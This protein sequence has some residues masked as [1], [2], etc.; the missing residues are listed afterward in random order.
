MFIIIIIN[1]LAC[2]IIYLF[3]F[4]QYKSNTFLSFIPNYNTQNSQNNTQNIQNINYSLNE[5]EKLKRDIIKLNNEN[6]LLK[7]ENQKLK[8]EN[9]NLKNDINIKNINLNQYLLKIKELN[10]TLA[11]KNKEINNLINKLQNNDQISEY[12][13]KD[14]MLIIQIKSVN[15]KVDMSFACKKTDIFARIEEKLYNEYPEFKDLNTYY[16]VGGRMVKRFRNM[17]ENNIKNNDKILL[18]IYE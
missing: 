3:I 12:I 5:I 15:Q 10:F 18:N 16:T 6:L 9:Q 13:K 4:I 7:N 11:N 8:N 1:I 17:Q 14:Q 2:I